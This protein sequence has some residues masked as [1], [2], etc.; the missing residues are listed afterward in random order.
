M[1]SE[2]L[3]HTKNKVHDGRTDFHFDWQCAS[4]YTHISIL[5]AVLLRFLGD[6]HWCAI[7]G[8][9]WWLSSH[10]FTKR[11]SE[12]LGLCLSNYRIA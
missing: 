12:N 1:T 6:R 11:C 10:F 4:A 7:K 9:S 2:F 5:I 8:I 3:N